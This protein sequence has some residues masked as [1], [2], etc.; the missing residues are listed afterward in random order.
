M[1][2]FYRWFESLMAARAMEYLVSSGKIANRINVTKVEGLKPPISKDGNIQP[3]HQFF[4]DSDMGLTPQKPKVI[5]FN[6]NPF[7]GEMRILGRVGQHSDLMDQ[8][9]KDFDGLLRGFY[10]PDIKE[11]VLRPMATDRQYDEERTK[12][13]HDKFAKLISAQL[14]RSDPDPSKPV[15]VV[16][17]IY[18]DPISNSSLASKYGKY[19]FKW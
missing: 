5:R 1:K 14:S 3:V 8:G 6:W 2:T 9:E 7:T 12:L 13:I 10:F 11:V 4:W 16:T 17:N 15:K 18:G 19:A